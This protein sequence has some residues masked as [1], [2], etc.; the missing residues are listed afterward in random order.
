LDNKRGGI[1][2]SVIAKVNTIIEA[3]I[4]IFPPGS[5]IVTIDYC[6]LG[7]LCVFDEYHPAIATT[8]KHLQFL[9]LGCPLV[10]AIDGAGDLTLWLYLL[11]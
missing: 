10:V 1:R 11:V 5:A 8:S 4:I 2:H 9:V 3:S 6:L 7:V